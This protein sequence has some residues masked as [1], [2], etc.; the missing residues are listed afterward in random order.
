MDNTSNPATQQK[1]EERK[2]VINYSD[3]FVGDFWRYFLRA[4]WLF[5]PPILIFFFR[6]YVFLEIKPGKGCNDYHI[7]EPKSIRIVFAGPAFLG[8]DVGSLWYPNFCER[9][10]VAKIY[11]HLVQRRIGRRT[12]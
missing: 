4:I 8:N 2:R 7:R 1:L 5:F 9:L 10:Q 3:L 11:Y 12:L 6:L